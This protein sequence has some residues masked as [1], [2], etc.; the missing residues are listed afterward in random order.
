MIV[1]PSP[2][3]LPLD[4]IPRVGVLED[5]ISGKKYKKPSEGGSLSTVKLLK[6]TSLGY[7]KGVT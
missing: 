1:L 2:K 3:I 7:T 5:D 4:L 6:R